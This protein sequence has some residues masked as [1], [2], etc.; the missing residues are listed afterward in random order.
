MKSLIIILI[1]SSLP[2][3]AGNDGLCR[4]NIAELKAKFFTYQQALNL[5]ARRCRRIV[6][7]KCPKSREDF[8]LVSVEL[9]K[10]EEKLK[11]TCSLG[12]PR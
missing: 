6:H 7:P 3:Y 9:K 12:R 4:K 1:F 8:F 5:V 10:L 11:E 2:L